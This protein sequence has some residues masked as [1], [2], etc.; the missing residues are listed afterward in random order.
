MKLKKIT[1]PCSNPDQNPGGSWASGLGW[2]AQ[3][4]RKS[5]AAKQSVNTKMRIAL[6]RSG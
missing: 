4:V 6:A 1:K 3:L 2:V 5:V